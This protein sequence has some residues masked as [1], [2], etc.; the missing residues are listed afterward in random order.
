MLRLAGE[1][2]RV[3]MAEVGG[4]LYAILDDRL[5]SLWW[6]RDRVF[7]RV[8]SSLGPTCLEVAAFLFV[9]LLLD[10]VL[11]LGPRSGF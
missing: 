3:A 1:R 8:L 10:L 2:D 7:C 9:N 6:A 11:H 5:L 4:K